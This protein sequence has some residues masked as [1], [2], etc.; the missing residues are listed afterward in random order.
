MAKYKKGLTMNTLDKVYLYKYFSKDNGQLAEYMEKILTR[1]KNKSID[2]IYNHFK[3][4]EK[5][6]LIKLT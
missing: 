4:K 2:H 1:G 5:Q 3:Y 6:M